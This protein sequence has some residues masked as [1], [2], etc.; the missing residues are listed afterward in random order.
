MCFHNKKNGIYFVFVYTISIW[1]VEI[2]Q[3]KKRENEMRGY[4]KVTPLEFRLFQEEL[5]SSLSQSGA[6]D[7]EARESIEKAI[8]ALRRA[9]KRNNI[10]PLYGE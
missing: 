8:K 3:F 4:I 10:P 1:F 5:E 2:V 7:E 6:M 9:E